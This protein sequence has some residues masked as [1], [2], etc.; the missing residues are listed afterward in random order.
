MSDRLTDMAL[1]YELM[2]ELDRRVVG[3]WY[4]TTVR[5]T[6]AREM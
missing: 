3:K 6:L 2:E 1:F 4:A 5:N